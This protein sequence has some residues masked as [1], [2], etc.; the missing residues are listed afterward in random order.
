MSAAAFH[1]PCV[2]QACLIH[3]EGGGGQEAGEISE[4]SCV[5]HQ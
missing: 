2:R 5:S 3:G 4:V 1:G